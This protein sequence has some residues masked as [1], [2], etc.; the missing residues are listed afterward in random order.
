MYMLATREVHAASRPHAVS[1]ADAHAHTATHQNTLPKSRPL[2]VQTP[3]AHDH[4]LV[5]TGPNQGPLRG[6]SLPAPGIT[7]DSEDGRRGQA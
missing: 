2:L 3:V 6:G 1:S 7:T 4:I 5:S